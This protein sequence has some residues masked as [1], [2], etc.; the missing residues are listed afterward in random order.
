MNRLFTLLC[1][2]LLPFFA[3]AQFTDMLGQGPMSNRLKLGVKGGANFI[4]LPNAATF[5]E[6]VQPQPG[7]QAGLYLRFSPIKLISLQA[8][9]LYNAQGW[10]NI[11]T[12]QIQVTDNGQTYQVERRVELQT[13][14]AYLSFPLNAYFNLSPKFSL[15]LG[16]EPGVLLSS[17]AQGKAFYDEING[18]NYSSVEDVAYD[19][20]KDQIGDPNGAY[21]TYVDASGNPIPREGN[22]YSNYLLNSNLTFRFGF[23]KNLNAE[24][25]F[26]YRINDLIN[27][28]Y[29]TNGNLQNLNKVI[30][31]QAMLAYEFPL[32]HARPNNV[33]KK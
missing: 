21:A 9:A 33:R 1:F 13:M 15:A 26:N 32:L 16:M 29:D 4:L 31:F 14:N 19:Y 24:L 10:E 25:R 11:Q 12:T 17:I 20:L 30:N 22:Y 23:T 3:V 18:G 7:Y 8:E 5:K 6:A 27:D 2:L 28:Y